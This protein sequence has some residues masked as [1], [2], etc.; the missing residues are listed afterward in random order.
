MCQER[1][2]KCLLSHPVEWVSVLLWWRRDP[3]Y[4]LT[5][6]L[7]AEQRKPSNEPV[8]TYKVKKVKD[9]VKINT[10]FQMHKRIWHTDLNIM[11]STDQYLKTSPVVVEKTLCRTSVCSAGQASCGWA[12]DCG[13]VCLC[14]LAGRRSS[15]WPRSSASSAKCCCTEG[16]EAYR[17]L[18]ET[19]YNTQAQN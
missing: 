15:T 2:I 5:E 16:S 13:R 3:Y 18:R 14:R 10:P 8:H 17:A 9:D 12:W 6:C 11:N 1:R 7:S 4:T 19:I